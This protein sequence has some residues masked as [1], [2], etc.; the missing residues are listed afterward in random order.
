MDE[1]RQERQLELGLRELLILDDARHHLI[2]CD[3]GELWLTQEGDRRD[4]V[5]PA[6]HAWLV[7]ATGPVV[8][9]ALKPATATLIQTRPGR[10]VGQPRRDGTAPLLDRL[11]RWRFPSLASFPSHLIF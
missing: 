10:P 11:R 1:T 9:S 5:L 8:L 3:S 2:R 4:R 6:G 7:E